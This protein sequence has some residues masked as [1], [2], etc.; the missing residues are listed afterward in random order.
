MRG[1]KQVTSERFRVRDLPIS[2]VW[3]W[4]ILGVSPP[5]I[6]FVSEKLHIS[7]R[8]RATILWQVRNHLDGYSMGEVD[9][10]VVETSDG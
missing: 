8:C 7:T 2:Q 1:F 6:S 4:H 9:G 10:D 5:L 3:D